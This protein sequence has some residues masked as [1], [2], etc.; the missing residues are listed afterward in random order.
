MFANTRTNGFSLP[1]KKRFLLGLY[2][3]EDKNQEEI[4]IKAKKIR[5]KIVN[6]IK[7][8]YKKNDCIMGPIFGDVAPLIDDQDNV[9][10]SITDFLI[11]D[12]F[13]GSPSISFADR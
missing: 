6:Y 10:Y 3:T 8:I 13:Y 2:C 11:V 5:R 7:E 12:N 9:D 4:F 1:V